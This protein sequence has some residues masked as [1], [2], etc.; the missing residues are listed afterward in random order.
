[1]LL[2]R[3]GEHLEEQNWLAVGLDLAM[4]VLGVF[5]GLQVDT[6][7]ERR[8]ER[9][10]E[11]EYLIRLHSDVTE[12]IEGTRFYVEFM[13]T[14]ADRA[15][16]VLRD[17]ERCSVPQ[18]DRVD[19]ANGLYHLGKLAPAS[20]SRGTIDELV[21]TGKLSILRSSAV[22]EELSAMLTVYEEFAVLFP[23]AVGRITPHVNYVDANVVFEIEEPTR[24]NAT[25]AWDDIE[26]DLPS[27]CRDRRFYA[28][29][30]AVRNYTYDVVTWNR[31]TLDAYEAFRRVLEVEI[32]HTPVAVPNGR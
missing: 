9:A 31:T 20:F 27:L 24:G 10:E 28:A 15:S 1:M 17:L 6:W 12:S 5:I 32:D 18:E 26:L 25:L 2:R 8:I 16:T 3:I 23:F 13:T 11:A 29:V 19:F 4:V 7:N 21:S 30:A 22:R 14:A